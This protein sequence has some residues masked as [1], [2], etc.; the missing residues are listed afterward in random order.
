MVKATECALIPS[1]RSSTLRSKQQLLSRVAEGLG[2]C[3]VRLYSCVLV[4]VGLPPALSL[5]LRV[6]IP[7]SFKLSFH[8]DYLAKVEYLS[9]KS[10]SGIFCIGC[11]CLS[12]F[13]RR[14]WMA[15]IT[16][17]MSDLLFHCQRPHCLGLC[18][19]VYEL[20]H[21]QRS[22]LAALDSNCRINLILINQQSYNL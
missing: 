11:R 13:P 18:F 14:D 21:L 6:L 19:L 9:T 4:P 20:V 3:W 16:P 8:R 12:I 22:E 10:S 2:Q 1:S 5:D 7:E 15:L 17:G